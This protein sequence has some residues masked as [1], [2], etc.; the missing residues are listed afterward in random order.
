MYSCQFWIQYLFQ[1]KSITSSSC[2]TDCLNLAPLV[3]HS[4]SI[5]DKSGRLL[6][7]KIHINFYHKGLTSLIP[8]HLYNDAHETLLL[9]SSSFC[10]VK[11]S[12][13]G[14]CEF[15]AIWPTAQFKIIGPFGLFSPLPRTPT[16][17]TARTTCTLLVTP[18]FASCVPGTTPSNHREEHKK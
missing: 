9:V 11:T 2:P 5:F 16:T 1:R 4:Q 7:G 15:L 10:F 13:A 3:Y 18:S 17:T 14:C 12:D 6:K 8:G